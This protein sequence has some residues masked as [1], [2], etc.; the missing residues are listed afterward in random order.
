[1]KKVAVLSLI[2][3]FVLTSCNRQVVDTT[4][5]FDRAI[6]KLPNGK[7]AEGTVQSWLDYEDG[8]QIQIVIDNVTYLTHISNV[9]LIND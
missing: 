2:S 5:S 4:Y 6:I 9:V 7:V 1:M 3:L 8:D